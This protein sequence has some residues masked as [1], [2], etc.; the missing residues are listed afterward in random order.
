MVLR[1]TL[2]TVAIKPVTGESTKEA[3]KPSRREC[4]LRPVNLWTTTAFCAATGASD[5]RH[6][7][8]PLSS[9]AR[10]WLQNS[11][12]RCRENEKPCRVE[13]CIYLKL[14]N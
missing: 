3:V 7:L 10:T 12:D 4:R 9:E 8:R 11:G 13:R 5:T 6:S 2:A 1:I 14:H